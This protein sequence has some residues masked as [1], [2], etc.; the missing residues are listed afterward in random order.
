MLTKDI[1]VP[2]DVPKKAKQQYT[3]N[4]FEL[5]QGS[6]NLF[7]L[8]GD[9]KVEHL[10]DDFY[11][12]GIHEDDNDPEHLFRIADQGFVGALATQLGLIARH[13]GEFRDVRY[14]VKLNSKTNAIPAS[15]KDPESAE[16]A[17]VADVVNFQRETKLKILGVGY[18]IY[19]GSVYEKKELEAAARVVREAHANGLVAIL[20]AY[21]RGKAIQK[22]ND[23]HLIAGAAGVAA[24]LGAD[25]AKVDAPDNMDNLKEALRAAGKTKV[26]CAGGTSKET[27][28]YLA[29]L[30][31]QMKAGAWGTATGRNIHQRG[32]P[33]AVKLCHAIRALVLDRKPIE[34]AAQFLG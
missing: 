23:P 12:T 6:G 34:D 2:L 10:N 33:E 24:T 7:L 19:I 31:A 17:T 22:K 18:T 25:F 9:Q 32:L 28:E 1:L 3:K 8:A 16:L 27:K 26:I 20:W 4:Y 14:V 29:Q 30:D 11:G 21:P 13:G 15:E 5:T